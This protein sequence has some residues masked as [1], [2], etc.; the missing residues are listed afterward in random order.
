MQKESLIYISDGTNIKWLRIFHLYGGFFK[1]QTS[2]NFFCKGSA[3]KVTPP[4]SFYK[5][6]KTKFF[7]KGAIVKIL[8]IRTGQILKKNDASQIIIF[9]NSGIILKNK[10]AFQSKYFY[11]PIYA[12]FKRKKI[13]LLFK[14]KI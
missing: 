12:H 8:V 6:F 4:I 1:K 9:N 14:A 2:I 11:G 13:K 5:G 7:L 10:I 3:K